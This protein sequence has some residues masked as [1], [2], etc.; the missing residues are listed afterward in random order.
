MTNSVAFRPPA[1][2]L[3]T[4]DPYFS[5]W[6]MHD[7]LF[8]GDSTHWTGRPNAL[9]GMLR[10]DGMPWRFLGLVD[11]AMRGQFN[12]NCRQP[13][14]MEQLDC[15]ITALSTVYTFAAGGVELTVRFCNA[16]LPDDLDLISRPV[17]YLD[18]A[19][20]SVD[21]AA[22]QV[23][24]YFD[25]SAELCV[26]NGGQ[27]V[28]GRRE[29]LAERTLLSFGHVDQ[30][31]LSRAGDDLRIDWGRVYLLAPAGTRNALGDKET[32]QTFI[33]EGVLGDDRDPA[34]GTV[35]EILP[36]MAVM[37]DFGSV[38]AKPR[39]VALELAYDDLESIEYFHR[40]LLA[41][42]RSRQPDF[43]RMF[44]EMVA[45]RDE[46]LTRSDRFDAELAAEAERAGGRRYRMLAELS[47]R[48]AISAHKLVLDEDGNVLFFSKENYSNG[49]IGTV[50]VSYPSMPLFLR[51]APELVKGMMRPIFRYAAMPEWP[52]AFAPHDV[53]C[54]PL[55][56]GQVYGDNK[57]EYQ[58]PVEECGNMLLMAAAV[59]RAEGNADF[60]RENWALL[61]RWA[62][63][64]DELG[65]EIGNQLCTDDFAGHLANNA[66]LAV[67]GIL[68]IA[69]HGYLAGLLGES[70]LAARRMVR[71]RE[72]AAAWEMRAFDGD[73]YVLAFGTPGSWSQKYNLV[74]DEML[75]F[76]LFPEKIRRTE[77]AWYLKH[78]SRYGIALD[79]RKAY[80]KADWVVWSASLTADP[81][82]FDALIEPVLRFLHESPSRVPFADWYGVTD[83][84]QQAFQARSV[85]GGIF[86]RQ[87]Q[88]FW[89]K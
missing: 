26:D 1:V 13:L 70:T 57:L 24:L 31:V 37:H 2:P 76:G 4:V 8:D 62:E 30:K 5:V 49:C 50:D 25:A 48:Q 66:N 23:S 88:A 28:E 83:G 35:G 14:G 71:A 58:M 18:F 51:Y 27:S 87:L 9:C 68:G 6:S 41:Y 40:P 29:I 20:K 42:W 33:R 53:G 85:V 38:T 63:Y 84:L 21:G 59:A 7:R 86:I 19:V 22:H 61:T 47:Y 39:S 17:T 45:R 36:L 73:H 55:A 60:A 52:H 12:W 10:I 80:T 34:A 32:R 46:L 69:A 79:N 43:Y 75:G 78:A 65:L 81:A 72:L 89:A 16:L 74:W 3:I 77:I 67:K 64:L 15:R 54:Y 44:E 82:E 11:P 56:N